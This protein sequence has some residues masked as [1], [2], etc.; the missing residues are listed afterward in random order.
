MVPHGAPQVHFLRVE[1]VNGNDAPLAGSAPKL[2]VTPQHLVFE[3]LPGRIYSL[4]YGQN[5]PRSRGSI[6][7][8]AWTRSRW[9]RRCQG[10]WGRRL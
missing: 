10:S 1:I 2:Y 5:A 8:A 6:W 3:Q 4:I 9:L 7:G